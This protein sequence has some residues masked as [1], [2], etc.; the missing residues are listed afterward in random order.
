MVIF[1]FYLLCLN[2]IRCISRVGF[3]LLLL[4]RATPTVYGSSQARDR[5]GATAA[6]LYHS[7]S[8]SESEPTAT[9]CSSQQHLAPQPTEQGQGSNPHPHGY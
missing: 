7:R 4:F 2:E 5:I 6:G 9:C 1:L 3:L 8:N